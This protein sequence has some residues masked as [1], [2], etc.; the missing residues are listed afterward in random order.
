MYMGIQQCLNGW[1]L[2]FYKVS[3]FEVNFSMAS[4]WA[5]AQYISGFRSISYR[6]FIIIIDV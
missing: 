1:K 5:G 6:C 3:L 2:D 4:Q